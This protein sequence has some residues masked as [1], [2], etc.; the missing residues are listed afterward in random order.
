LEACKGATGKCASIK[1]GGEAWK[2][3]SEAEKAQFQKKYEARKA[4]FDKDMA[5]FLAAGG[6]KTK[7]AAGLRKERKR[8]REGKTKDENAPKKPAGGGFGV[9]I[10]DNRATIMKSL[11]PGSKAAE[12]TKIG[13]QQW[14]ALSD[15]AKKPF[16][17]KFLKKMDEY[18]V[19][20]EEYQANL[21][22]ESEAED[23]GSDE[24]D[25][26]AVAKA[27]VSPLKKRKSENS[28]SLMDVAK[29][30]GLH[31]KLKAMLDNPKI[32]SLGSQALLDAL[33]AAGGKVPD[34]KKALLAK[35]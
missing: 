29:K 3:T 17:D 32:A 28:D 20:I 10:A 33:R 31:M 18:K 9:Y 5:A 22:E 24:E 35:K 13:G 23:A 34:A 15:E 19:A 8:A 2:N 11:P 12:V 26:D 6:Q 16:Q 21:P 7:G 25:S 14:S 27:V 30:E 1:M 4:Q